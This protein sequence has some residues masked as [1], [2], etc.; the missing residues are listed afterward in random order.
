M[1]LSAVFDDA[2][3]VGGGILVP[4]IATSQRLLRLERVLGFKKDAGLKD[5]EH[6]LGQQIGEY[7]KTLVF[8]VMY[9][10]CTLQ[11]DVAVETKRVN[12]EEK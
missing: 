6:L 11:R 8:V 12:A 10:L 1:H 3:N 2:L 9:K 7:Q 5:V 4:R